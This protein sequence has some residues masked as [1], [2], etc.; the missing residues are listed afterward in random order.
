MLIIHREKKGPTQKR[1]DESGKRR[2]GR[3]EA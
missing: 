2:C 3:E 1:A